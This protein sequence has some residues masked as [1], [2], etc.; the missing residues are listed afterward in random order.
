[1]MQLIMFTMTKLSHSQEN[2]KVAVVIII[3]M[4]LCLKD[5]LMID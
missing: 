3:H 4:L 2:E 5:S 1:M